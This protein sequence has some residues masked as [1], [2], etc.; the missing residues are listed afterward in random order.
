M[1]ADEPDRLSPA[2]EAFAEFLALVEEGEDVD[3]DAFC[4]EREALAPKLRR[5]HARWASLTGALDAVGDGER[6]AD[7]ISARF[8]AV[9]PTIS[10]RGS[11]EPAAHGTLF[12]RDAGD[13]PRYTLGAEIARGG[14]GAILEVWDRDLRRTLA[15][16]VLLGRDGDGASSTGGRVE[17]RAVSRFLEEAQ[18]TGQL[19]HPGIVPVHELGL[20]AEGRVYFTMSLVRG[21]DFQA[22]LKLVREEREDWS[23][24]RAL[25]VVQRVCETLAYAH[26]RG[27]V[28]RDLKPSNVMVGRY[29]ETYV[30]DW[31]FARVLEPAEHAQ[32]RPPAGVETGLQTHRGERDDSPLVTRDGDVVGTPAY[33]PPEQAAGRIE[34]VDRRSDVYAVGA[35]LYQLLTGVRPYHQARGQARGPARRKRLSAAEVIAAVRRGAPTPVHVLAPS[36]PPELV[37]ICDKAMAREP[38]DRYADT[39]EMA[40]DL[41]AYLEVRVVRA[42]RSGAL[43]ELA[44][45]V[46]R[47]RALAVASAAAA[48]ALVAGLVA[49][50]ILFT[51]AE[52][53]R[54]QVL[55]LADHRRLQGLLAGAEELWPARPERVGAYEDW[56]GEARTLLERRDAQHRPTL[57]AMEAAPAESNEELW[58]RESLADLV[59]RLDDFAAVTVPDVEARLDWARRVR[60][61]TTDGPAAA[62]LWSEAA[63]AIG[64]P[65]RC[66]QYAG[67]ELA[68]Q[69]GLVPIGP[70][71]VSGLWEFAHPR[72]GAIPERDPATGALSIADDTAL[73]FVLVP[74]GSFLMGGTGGLEQPRHRVTLDPFFLSKYEMSQGQW[75]RFTGANPS[76]YG[77]RSARPTDPTFKYSL[78]FAVEQVTWTECERVTRRLGL[79]LPTEAQWEY[80]A[81]AGTTTP[82][83]TGAERESL[84]GSVNLADQSAA[85][86]GAQWS[87]IQDWPELDDGHTTVAPVGSYRPNAFGLH[88]V[89]GNVWEWCAD[90]WISYANPVRPGDGLR[91]LPEDP[92]EQVLERI[93]RGGGFYDS[94]RNARSANRMYQA[95][96]RAY[97]DVGLRPARAIER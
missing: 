71:P 43:A 90:F 25:A 27:V 30:M 97:D 5:L 81:R 73:V 35:M 60:E 95:T 41:R 91:S 34:A 51:Q 87:E 12:P 26:E 6:L 92:D 94:A 47:N 89:H 40:E 31:G 19:D 55:R 38:A 76:F 52:E 84:A 14:F 23:V 88:D 58:H 42:W 2:G 82:W 33:M 74:G 50:L 66:P 75:V 28:H 18:I 59:N 53:A 45:W 67:L 77:P 46:Q 49:T 85:R 56:L 36:V 29:G 3:F 93:N 68:P 8:G 13:G 24:P 9:D 80:A 86:A 32:P 69:V 72:T 4:A 64:D 61:L 22:I 16:K 48:V 63:A 83:S 44:K 10:L 1:T 37:A 39:M 7:R 15:M 79:A 65:D 54:A 96:S 17:P 11:E 62:A 78:R 70:D 20:D 57:A 21:R